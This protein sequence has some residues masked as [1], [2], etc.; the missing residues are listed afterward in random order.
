MYKILNIYKLITVYG[1]NTNFLRNIQ[2]FQYL[3]MD[4]GN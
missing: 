4:Q 3:K 2:A 1:E